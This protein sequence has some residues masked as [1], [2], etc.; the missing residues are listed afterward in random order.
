MGATLREARRRAGLTQR[1]LAERA[2]TSQAAVARYEAGRVT[3]DLA[4]FTRLLDA[5]DHRLTVAP[6]PAPAADPGVDRSAIRRLLA[7]SVPERVALVVE[8][9]RAL[10][11]FDRA[12]AAA[13]R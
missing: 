3:P 7:M 5:C 1:R 9:G 2:G 8:E 6:T 4:T 12:V 11:R 13:R 10:T